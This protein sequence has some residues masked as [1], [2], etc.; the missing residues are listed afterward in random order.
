MITINLLPLHL[1]PVK[2]TPLPHI[3]SSGVLL[4][5][6]LL[7]ASVYFSNMRSIANV[8]ANLV[9]HQQELVALQ[10]VVDEYNSLSEQKIAV[11]KQVETIHEM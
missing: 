7:I 5:V 6:L 4:L 8:Q 2:R 1:R 10:P 9:K 11:S 3:L